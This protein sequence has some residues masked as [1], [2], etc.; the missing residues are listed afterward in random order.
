MANGDSRKDD[1]AGK[2]KNNMEDIPMLFDVVIPG[3]YLP[4]PGE[5][6]PDWPA[7]RETLPPE[8]AE[9]F[10]E[11]TPD[12]EAIEG[13]IESAIDAALPSATE[14]AVCLLRE[15]IHG[16]IRRALGL[17]EETPEGEASPEAPDDSYP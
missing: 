12:M 5:Q 15:A 16:E 3:D 6:Q 8:H 11:D 1:N 13:L 17:E 7:E 2:P 4:T 10:A 14:A 9:E